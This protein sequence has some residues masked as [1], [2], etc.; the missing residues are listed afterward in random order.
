M[1]FDIEPYDGAPF[2]GAKLALYL[3]DALA[4]LLRD[5]T[6]DLI[7]AGYWDLPGGGREGSETPLAL[8][9]A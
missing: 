2:G 5:A 8:C 9:A 3:G 6:P 7:W 1:K 4:V